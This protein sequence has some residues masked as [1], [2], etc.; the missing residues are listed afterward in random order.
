MQPLL[1]WKSI[2]YYIFWVFM[3]NLRYPTCNQH[4]PYCRMWC[5]WL[6]N[7]FSHYLKN[8]TIF[9]LK[10]VE[11]KMHILIFSTTLVWNISHSKKNWARY[12]QKCILI[13]T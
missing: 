3:F 4:T 8:G 5:V 1:Q 11:H 10:G 6:Y 7:I 13:F 12:D 9:F 2:K